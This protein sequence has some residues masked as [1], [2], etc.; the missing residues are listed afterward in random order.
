MIFDGGFKNE[1]QDWGWAPHEVK[2]GVPARMRFNNYGGWIL[3]HPDLTGDFGALVFRVK[4]PP[5]EGEFLEVRVESN[6]KT[7]FPRIKISPDHRHEVGDGWTDVM[8]L[9][10][11]LNPDGLPFDRVVMR[12]FREVSDDWISIDKVALTKGSGGARPSAS[13]D[14]TTLPR[15]ALSIDCRV[16]PTKINP[17]IYGMAQYSFN[18]AKKQEAQWKLDATARRFG[19]NTTSTYN[20]EI[21]AWNSG[22]DYFFNNFDAPSWLDFLKDNDAHGMASV[23]TV[24]TM[25]WVSKDKTSFSFPVSVFGAQEATDPYRPDAGNGKKNGKPIPP[26]PQSRAYQPITPAFVKKW[27][28]AIRARDAKNGKR[29]VQMYILDNEPAIWSTTHRDAHPDPL[30][31][32]ELLQRIIDYGTAVRE[33]DRDAIIAG[34]AE[35]GWTGYFFSGKDMTSPLHP[36]RRAH[37]DMPLLPWLL[38][39]L[40]EHEKKTGV[41]V[42]DVVDVHAY[43]YPDRVYSEAAD[44]DL[45]AL[46]L[47]TTRMLW[48]PTYVDESW[49]KEPVRLLPRLRDWIDQNYPGRG[50]SLGEWNFGGESH[51]SGGLAT[52]EALG[53]FGQAGITS[54]FY[55]TYPPEGS[56]SMWAFKAF[57]NYDGKGAHFLDWSVPTTVAANTSF[58]ASKD[59]THVVAVALNTSRKIAVTAHVDLASCGHVATHQSFSY[60]GG[61]AGFVAGAVAQGASGGADGVDEVLP[62]YSINVFDIQL[63][64]G[65][66]DAP[67]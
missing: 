3:A 21:N 50:I 14:A 62:P 5:G 15:V 66:I 43:P 29:S 56:P 12:A 38:K 45:A 22:Q 19:G 13:Y 63:S 23:V 7:I 2:P 52:A 6:A 33:A 1:W 53:R 51:M 60:A 41:R 8:V 27:V 54:A 30:T 59:G 16:K 32:D 40:A 55:W 39:Q 61:P 10:T 28:E 11:E 47:R 42:L 9:M 36:D 4:M 57:R 44:G 34:P 25:G 65:K 26:G 24:P 18:D 58:F 20:W 49:V 35:W 31:Y 64:D 67:K 46:R 37:G 17:M 48:D